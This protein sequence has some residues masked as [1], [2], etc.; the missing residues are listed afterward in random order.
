MKH[1]ASGLI[2][3]LGTPENR[4][5]GLKRWRARLYRRVIAWRRARF[6][7]YEELFDGW[8]GRRSLRAI[9]HLWRRHERSFD[10]I[11]NPKGTKADGQ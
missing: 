1:H 3:P 4:A 6:A 5:A 11:F 7:P 9:V 2:D 10:R 8:H